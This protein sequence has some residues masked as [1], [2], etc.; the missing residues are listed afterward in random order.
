MCMFSLINPSW[1]ILKN[2]C[3][4]MRGYARGQADWIFDGGVGQ[5]IEQYFTMGKNIFKIK[6]KLIDSQLHKKLKLQ[7]WGISIQS[8]TRTACWYCMQGRLGDILK[9]KNTLNANTTI[10]ENPVLL[11]INST[12]SAFWDTTSHIIIWYIIIRLLCILENTSHLLDILL[13]CHSKPCIL[14]YK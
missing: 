13:V 12:Q 11:I 9:G 7:Y 8:S 5:K 4:I 1:S 3:T 10:A 6:L 2:T 14:K